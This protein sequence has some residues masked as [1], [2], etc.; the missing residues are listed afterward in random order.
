[1]SLLGL[2]HLTIYIILTKLDKRNEII[3]SPNVQH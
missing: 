2:V 1:M 3:I